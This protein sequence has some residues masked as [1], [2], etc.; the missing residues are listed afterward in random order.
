MYENRKL[1]LEEEGERDK[2]D[3]I[4]QHDETILEIEFHQDLDKQI[5]QYGDALGFI[6][7][8]LRQT[9]SSLRQ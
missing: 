6:Q 2:M 3:R 8:Q 1:A 5:K 7:E 9:T 4:E